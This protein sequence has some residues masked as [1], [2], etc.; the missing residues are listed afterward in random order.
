[1][2]DQLLGCF[3]LADDLLGCVHDAFHGGVA[4]P[5]WPDA[6]PHSLLAYL[7]GARHVDVNKTR[8]VYKNCRR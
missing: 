4:E 5:A 8:G 1:M 7:R 3:K 2:C 6:D